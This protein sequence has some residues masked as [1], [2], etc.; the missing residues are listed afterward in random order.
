MRINIKTFSNNSCCNAPQCDF[1]CQRYSRENALNVCV[2]LLELSALQKE[3]CIK[4]NLTENDM[5]QEN[6]I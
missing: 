3:K 5:K 2:T 4:N 1:S 6:V